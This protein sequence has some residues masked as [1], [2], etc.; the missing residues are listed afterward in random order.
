MSE[1]SEMPYP[2]ATYS[3]FVLGVLVVASLVSFIDRQ[4]VAIVVEPMKAD[5]GAS[6]T[7]IGWLYGIFAVF[8]A[9]AGLPIAYLADRMSRKHIIAAGIF[10]WSIMTMLCGLSRSFW[11][12]L[13]ARIGVGIGEATLTPST[14]SLVGDYFPRSSIPLAMSVFQT[15]AIMG[16]GLAFIIGGVVLGL[17]QGAEPLVLPGVGALSAWQQ[18]FLYVGAP[19][20]LLAVLLLGIREPVRRSPMTPKASASDVA[21][22]FAEVFA[23]YKRHRWTML[24][25]HL[26][27]LAFGL[28]GYAFVFWTVSYFSR[29]HGVPPASASQIFGWIFLLVGPLGS[30][31]AGFQARW[32]NQ[33]G[34]ADGNVL[35]GMIGG[36]LAVVAILLIQAAP[37]ATIAFALY[38]PALFFVNSP[39]G[40]A[41]GALSVITPP[42][43]RAQV[44]A[45]YMF[46][47]AM[48]MLLGPPIAG[49]VSEH[50]F[51]GAEG[52]RYSVATVALTFGSIG[53]V[54]LWF[55][56]AHYARSLREMDASGANA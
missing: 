3:W 22:S 14:I 29:V 26:G 49:A 53:V 4:V 50:L 9:V 1:H 12:V 23:H 30:V 16:S 42:A 55:G 7:E 6:D 32:F 46:V 20:L 8:Y 15:G 34:R 5:L 24:F 41:L 45:V 40:I 36:C 47:S 2:R 44:G 28:L 19:G 31:W 27:F 43:I 18:T 56:R 51:P 39:F 48:G 38:V 35:V 17:V 54:L 25:H 21:R 33:R 52:V 11:Q 10:F 37:T 13:F